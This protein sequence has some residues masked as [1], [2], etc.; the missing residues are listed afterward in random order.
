MLYRESTP[1]Q[2]E[3]FLILKIQNEIGTSLAVAACPLNTSNYVSGIVNFSK[4]KFQYIKYKGCILHNYR[5][6]LA[7]NQ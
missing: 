1:I 6:K 3:E 4:E 2:S 7:K 5:V